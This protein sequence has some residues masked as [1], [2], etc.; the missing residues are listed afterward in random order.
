MCTVKIRDRC[1]LLCRYLQITLI[2]PTQFTQNIRILSMKSE[3]A[4]CKNP[5]TF[6]HVLYTFKGKYVDICRYLRISANV[7]S[8]WGLCADI[9]TKY[10]DD[11]RIWIRGYTGISVHRSLI[12]TVCSFN[13]YLVCV[14]TEKNWFMLEQS[15]VFNN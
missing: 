14:D 3:D 4:I 10:A 8:L 7:C 2:I 6:P 13:N 11:W 9:C 5:W 12:L 15:D 1:T